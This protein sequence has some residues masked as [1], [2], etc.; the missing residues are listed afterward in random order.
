[1]L[2]SRSITLALAERG[3]RRR[4]PYLHGAKV[5][6]EKSLGAIDMRRRTFL[7][8]HSPRQHLSCH[9]DPG[10][11]SWREENRPEKARMLRSMVVATTSS[12]G[13]SQRAL[14]RLAPTDGSADS[15]RHTADDMAPLGTPRT[16]SGVRGPVGPHRWNNF[17]WARQDPLSALGRLGAEKPV[18]K[19]R[20][21]KS[22]VRWIPSS[23]VGSIQP[24]RVTYAAQLG[25]A[26][27]CP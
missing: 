5:L 15:A 22:F 23:V 14:M 10:N 27:A 17:P 19:R 21:F 18:S 11:T 8:W 16:G 3:E 24:G 25:P 6:Q 2:R 26:F 4:V 12:T 9:V 13:S 20:S 1:M 7:A